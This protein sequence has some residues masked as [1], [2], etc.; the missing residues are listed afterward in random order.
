[1][2]SRRPRPSSKFQVCWVWVACQPKHASFGVLLTSHPPVASPRVV[3]CLIGVRFVDVRDAAHMVAGDAND[4]F[5]KAILDFALRVQS[6]AR[7]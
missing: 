4:V 2:N 6:P 1:M 7:L 3:T 5:T